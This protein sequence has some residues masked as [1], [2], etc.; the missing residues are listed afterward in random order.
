M[1]NELFHESV[2]DA[3]RSAIAMMGGFEAVGHEIWPAKSR[4]AAGALLSDVLN[5][6]RNN[7]FS[8]DE[9]VLFMRIARDRGVHLPMYFLCDEIGYN[10]PQPVDTADQKGEVARQMEAA[11]RLFDSALKRMER[12]QATEALQFTDAD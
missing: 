1:Q 3:F 10:K 11:A 8:L 4:K 5:V 12:L 6:D 2:T 7:K 9:M